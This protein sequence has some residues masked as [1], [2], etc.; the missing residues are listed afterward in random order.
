MQVNVKRDWLNKFVSASITNIQREEYTEL[1]F[2]LRKRLE[3]CEEKL[4]TFQSKELEKYIPSIKLEIKQ[5]QKLIN[6]ME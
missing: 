6:I 4:E 2:C 1:I 5:V 3:E